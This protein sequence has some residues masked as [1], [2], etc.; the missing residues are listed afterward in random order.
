MR[1]SDWSSDVCSSDLVA[2][3]G[4][5]EG[6]LRRDVVGLVVHDH[7]AVTVLEAQV[8]EALDELALGGVV[9][10][11]AEQHV[12]GHRDVELAVPPGRSEERGVG[13]EGVRKCRYRWSPSQ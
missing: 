8:D 6:R 3:E 7:E 9:G 12:G 11:A 13:K 1:I 5:V 10:G 4:C 2:V